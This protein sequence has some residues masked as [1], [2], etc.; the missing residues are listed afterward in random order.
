MS[1][2]QKPPRVRVVKNAAVPDT[3]RRHDRGSAAVAVVDGDPATVPIEP[4]PHATA[5]MLLGAAFMIAAGAGGI[6][7]ALLSPS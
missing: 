3:R 1:H 6:L 4:A 5:T 7:V 2:D